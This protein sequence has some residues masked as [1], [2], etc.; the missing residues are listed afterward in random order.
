MP[1]LVITQTWKQ[2]INITSRFEKEL[3]LAIVQCFVSVKQTS[4][5]CNNLSKSSIHQKCSNHTFEAEM[6]QFH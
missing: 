3:N 4:Y 2:T 6:Q 5:Q 1:L